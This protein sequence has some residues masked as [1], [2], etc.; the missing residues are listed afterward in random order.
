MGCPSAENLSSYSVI[1]FPSYPLLCKSREMFDS[2]HPVSQNSL[3]D[4]SKKTVLSVFKNISLSPERSSLY[5][6]RKCLWVS[7]RFA[8]LF[9]GQGSLK[10]RYILESSQGAK[11]SLR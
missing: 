5:I 3:S 1:M 9:L 6:S 2:L 4:D 10:L 11:I 8:H 7:L